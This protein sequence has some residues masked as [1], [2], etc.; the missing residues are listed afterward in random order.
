[1]SFDHRAPGTDPDAWTPVLDRVDT[2]PIA[3]DGYDRVLVVA[4][5][6]DDETLGAGGLIAAAADAGLPVHVVL[7]SRGEGSHPDSPTTSPEDLSVR[8]A[9]EFRTA[10]LALHP[11]VT[12]SVLD[13]PDGGLRE[14]P[15]TLADAL[16]DHLSAEA[17]PPG[18]GRTLVVAPWQ[19]DGHRDHRVAG[20]V[21]ARLVADTPDVD[22]LAY[23]VWAWHWDDPVAPALPLAR[24]RA[25][26][27][28]SA[29]LDRKRRALDAH[30][31][32]VRPLS[33][34]PGDEAIVDDR[35]A[36]HH[37][38]DREWFVDVRTDSATTEPTAP[39]R[40]R[41]SFDAHYDRKPEG[42]DFD[43]SWYEQRKRAVTLAALPRRRYRSALE[44][45]CAT[46][47]LTA[48][49]T[50]R[51]DAV[52]GTDISRAPLERARR[53][54]PSARFVQAALPT[55]W[56]DGR[57]DLVVMSEVG[58]YLSPADLDVTIDRVL[59]S[60][61]DDGVLVA[62]HWR[63]PDSDA[64]TDGDT[65]DAH[66]AA[67][68]PRPALVRHV[69]PDFVLSVLPGPSVTSVARAEGLVR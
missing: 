27:L 19:G 64:V 16:A 54:A 44:L 57:W 3:L 5:H 33:S 38:R 20:E 49:L 50:E 26:P 60:L 45:G 66:L 52:L 32:Q 53:R 42:W 7:V 22:L 11:T 47:V 65:V 43:G 37:I 25:L 69:E 6:P 41:E 4:P 36:R 34:A 24:L 28:S 48:A 55:E 13:V 18:A 9:E 39:S 68:W 8:R 46:G 40:S 1:M 35:H 14:Q 21:A 56:P 23:P 15:E 51:A 59:A 61:D 17:D 30:A 31:S 2:A 62:C 67:R 12:W 29:V 58:Y 10:L 63:H